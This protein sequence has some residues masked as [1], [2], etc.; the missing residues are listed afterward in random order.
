MCINICVTRSTLDTPSKGTPTALAGL[1][2]FE[3]L[4]EAE[5]VRQVGRDFE[6]QVVTTTTTTTAM[7]KNQNIVHHI[8][9]CCCCLHIKIQEF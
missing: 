5:T 4:V 1:M 8:L 3:E 7:C 2:D 9:I 6:Q